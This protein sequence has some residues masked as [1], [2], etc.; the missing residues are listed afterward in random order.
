MTRIK[1]IISLLVLTLIFTST[2]SGQ[3]FAIDNKTV[4]FISVDAGQ[5]FTIALKS[6]GTVW[7][8]G[9]NDG[10]QL[11]VGD[12]S[13]RAGFVKVTGLKDII[14][15]SAASSHCVALKKDGTVW[16]WG[17]N[18]DGELGDG[19]FISK[20]KPVKV[21]NLTNVKVIATGSQHTLALKKDGT[22]WAWG[23]NYYSSLGNDS[24]TKRNIPVKVNLLENVKNIYAYYEDSVAV[25][26]DGSVWVWGEC[27][28]YWSVRNKRKPIKLKGIS[29]AEKLYMFLNENYFTKKDGSLWYWSTD[30]YGTQ[31]KTKQEVPTYVVKVDNINK[32][33]TVAYMDKALIALKTDGTLWK[34]K[35]DSDTPSKI[36][37]IAN[38][39]WISA[40][41]GSAFAIKNDGT[42]WAWGDN[43]C[44]ELGDGSV[45]G[46]LS[47]T[48]IMK[49]NA[50]SSIYA[51]H[52]GSLLV[53]NDG[54]ILG[55]GSVPS[56]TENDNY[57]TKPTTIN[58]FKDTKSVAAAY[59]NL[60]VLNKDG[61][62]WDSSFSEDIVLDDVIDIKGGFSHSMALKQDGSVYAWGS[63]TFG[64]L[65]SGDTKDSDSP[66]KVAT[67]SNIKAIAIS[68]YSSFAL[69]DDGTVWGWGSNFF[70]SSNKDKFII[71]NPVKIEGLSDIVAIAGG[72]GIVDG[73]FAALKKDGTVYE[74]GSYYTN[75][76]YKEK[77][78]PAKV[79]GL[80]DIISITCGAGYYMALKKDGT[81][82]TWGK[83]ESG[84]LGDGTVI[85]SEK[86]KMIK[87]LSDIITIAAGSGHSLALDK[88][89][90]V[91]AWGD[92]MFGQ[93]GTG[94]ALT[95]S[96][97][98]QVG[99][100][101]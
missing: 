99:I 40:D 24:T 36:N 78:T 10:G 13:Y 21:K 6:D 18:T 60:T 55:V 56:F 1:K 44:G 28:S 74:M 100:S 96:K 83:N 54:E 68:G 27:A 31:D 85:S 73:A 50:I 22:V 53:T 67:L 72:N 32:V 82:W 12:K 70:I 34:F 37:G 98:I 42:L 69:K 20:S 61:T 17:R 91:W 38:I 66:I 47:P 77:T 7:T 95:I 51:N 87:G 97:P 62:V 30:D 19:T 94:R 88:D 59:F 35:D 65:G 79:S 49:S 16:T 58:S 71:S 76:T 23:Y 39:K 93:L 9:K 52:N 11:G 8:A 64:G 57:I 84:Q 43:Y 101:K 45:Q 81:V 75:D 90:T 14:A 63:N 92:N 29:N 86:P 89:G 4:K 15:V 80:S 2:I 46:L 26:N 48:S 5:W 41:S 3:S 25:K 33:K